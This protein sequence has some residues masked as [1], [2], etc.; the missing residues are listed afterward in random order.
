VRVHAV[1]I[2]TDDPAPLVACY[3][4]LLGT[5]TPRTRGLEEVVGGRGMAQG[6]EVGGRGVVAEGGGE[7]EPGRVV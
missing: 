6:I 4:T 5:S 2:V 3:D 7:G 1:R